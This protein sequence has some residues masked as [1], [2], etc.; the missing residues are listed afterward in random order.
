MRDH[1]ADF[2]KI[3]AKK[4]AKCTAHEDQTYATLE[5]GFLPLIEELISEGSHQKGEEID[6][7]KAIISAIALLVHTEILR[8]QARRLEE[9]YDEERNRDKEGSP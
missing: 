4:L 2:K 3:L 6:D 9:Q 8:R 5:A 1:D 7:R